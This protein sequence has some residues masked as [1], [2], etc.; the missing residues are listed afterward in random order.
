MPYDEKE[1]LRH[2]ADGNADSYKLLFNRYWDQIYSTVF[3]F[4]KYPETSADLTQDIFAHIWAK[5]KY[6]LSVNNFESYLYISARNLIFDRLRKKEFSGSRDNFFRQYFSD[7]VSD[8][9][10]SLQLEYKEFHALIHQAINQ[11]TPQQQSVFKL[12]RFEGLNHAE[13]ADQMGLSK[14][15]VK[16]YMVNAIKFIRD[17][18]KSHSG[19]LLVYIWIWIF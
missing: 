1:L 13:I 12:S 18:L 4:T 6:L 14:R 8:Q 19:H 10:P 11:L 17:Y 3:Y 5:R 9:D 16:N 15:T 2:I 7:T